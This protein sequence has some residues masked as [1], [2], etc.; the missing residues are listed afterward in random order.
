MA[1][2]LD[3]HTESPA[4]AG[5]KTSQNGADD[6]F[7]TA[8]RRWRERVASRDIPPAKTSSGLDLDILY[9]PRNL[10]D[11]D[12]LND[13]GLPGDY[14]FTRGVQPTMYRERLWTMRQYSGFATPK[15]SNARYRWLLEQGQ[16]GISVALDLPTQLGM[17]SD[18]P[19]A[20]DDVGRVGVAVDTLADMEI[21]FEGI[22][23][24]RISTSFTINATASILLAM[25]VAVAE[26]QGVPSA[27]VAGT[28]QND[29]LKEYVARG[30]WIFPPEPSLRLIADTIEYCVKH[31]PRFNP[32]SVAGA[33][34]RDAG[35]TAVQD[36]A[37]T[38][39]R[40]YHLRT[41]LHRSR[42]QG[43]RVRHAD[44]LL[45]LHAQRLLRGG[46]QVSRGSPAVGAG[47]EGAVRRER[48][49]SADVSFRRSMRRQHADRAAAA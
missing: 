2:E 34:F 16:T 11:I 27:E 45:L 25:Y 14:P 3:T 13:I 31:A 21:L 6:A 35:A 9:T 20:A 41:A 5:A 38:L 19:E 37:Y 30:T 44:Q 42:A 28:T 12:Q 18:D 40:R 22:P 47:D 29:I 10:R 17:D 1:R 15:E 4:T 7:A 24:D 48:P 43:Q 33:H 46:R 23:L 49:A 36:L 39:V 26:R 8:E 32:I